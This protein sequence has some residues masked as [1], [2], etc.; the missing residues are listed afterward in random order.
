VKYRPPAEEICLEFPLLFTTG[1]IA[2]H[3]NAGSMTRRSPSLIEREPELFVELNPEDAAGLGICAGDQVEVSTRRGDASA[4]ARLTGRVRAG[5]VFMP[6]HY[7]GTNIL[8]VEACD[9]E[10]KIPEFKVAA[11]K[12]S[13]R[14]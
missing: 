8:T 3:H 14:D 7:P 5:T 2:V 1:R 9:P 12:I 13:R 10:A 11:C 4:V 6:F